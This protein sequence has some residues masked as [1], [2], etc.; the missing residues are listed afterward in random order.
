MDGKTI[1]AFW[2]VATTHD[3]DLVNMELFNVTVNGVKVPVLKNT[4]VIKA[5]SRLLKFQGVAAANA[6]SL[7]LL[8]Q[9]KPRDTGCACQEQRGRAAGSRSAMHNSPKHAP[10]LDPQQALP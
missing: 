4:Q 1:D 3:R 5:F 2:W 10:V 6:T 7:Q 8:P 9:A